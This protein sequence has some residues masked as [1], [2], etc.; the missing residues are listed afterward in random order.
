MTTFRNGKPF[1]EPGG[2]LS[3][4][5]NALQKSS[6]ANPSGASKTVQLP[7]T[8]SALA[9]DTHERVSLSIV[10]SRSRFPQFWIVMRNSSVAPSVTEICRSKACSAPSTHRASLITSRSATGNAASSTT[11]SSPP[12]PRHTSSNES[13]R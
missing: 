10:T 9:G 5:S 11:K 3:A 4:A 13:A 1:I 6:E 8:K 7:G 12:G 2:E